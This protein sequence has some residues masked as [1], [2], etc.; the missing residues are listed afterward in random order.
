MLIFRVINFTDKLLQ[1][2]CLTE[3]NAFQ[4]LYMDSRSSK[5]VVIATRQ[6]IIRTQIWLTCEKLDNYL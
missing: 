3:K 4:S 5:A 1:F 6:P 2:C